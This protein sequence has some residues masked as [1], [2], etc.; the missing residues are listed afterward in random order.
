MTT[1]I[2]QPSPA[3]YDKTLRYLK[4]VTVE[5]HEART[6]LHQ[7]RQQATEPIAIVG[8]ACRYPGGVSSPAD[9]WRLVADGQD[10]ITEFPVDRGWDLE[11]IF[12]PDPDHAGTSYTKSGGFIDGA[13]DFDPAFFGIGP[14]EALAMD[15][16]QRLLLETSWEA[17]EDAGIDPTALR[18]SATGV[19]AG[20]MYSDYSWLT[21]S[22]P[23]ELGGHW[24]IGSAGSVA[25]GRV[26]YSFG[27]EGPAMTVDTACSSSLVALHLACQSL[28]RGECSL[29]LAGGATVLATPSVFVEFSRQRGL[30]P[31]GRCKSFAAAA[32]GTGWAEGVGVLL[33]ER[34]SDALRLGHPVLATVRGSAVNQDGASNGLTAPNGLAQERVVRQAL[35]AAGLEPS[36]VDVVEGHGTGTTLGDPIE[37]EALLATYGRDRPANRPLWL[38]S[39]KSNIGHTQA[40][41]GVAGIIKM[42][43]AMRGGRIPM[44]LH[45]DEPTPKV[46]WQ[47]GAVS[48]ATE[49]V[50]WQRGG[51]PRRAGVSSFGISGT[52]AHVILEEVEPVKPAAPGHGTAPV[53]WVLSATSPQAL[54]G[55]AGRLR[56][57]LTSHPG[58][59]MG[60]V[61]A[62]LTHSRARFNHRAVVVGSDRHELLTGLDELARGSLPSNAV[63]GIAGR[64]GKIV[65]LFSGQ[66]SQRAGMG[67]ELAEVYPVF[68]NALAEVC[69]Y[70]DGYLDRPLREVMF[71]A[72]GALTDTGPRL[73]DSP[74]DLLHQTR[75]AQA[76]LFALEVALFR[77]V[78]SWG[79]RPDYLLGHS[80]GEL[81]AAHVA[82]VLSLHDASALVAARGQLMQSMP[83]RGAMIAVQASAAEIARSIAGQPDRVAIA[84]VNGPS[85]VVLSGDE[86]AVAAQAEHWAV[87]GRR[88]RRLRVSH[89]FHSPLLDPILAEF[90]EVAGGLAYHRPTIPIVSNVTGAPVTADEVSNPQYWMR[91]ARS[92]VRFL[93]GI[94]WLESAGATI[95]LELGPN[96]ALTALAKDCLTERPGPVPALVPTLRARWPEATALVGSCA[97]LHMHG[98]DV[99]WAAVL[100]SP[101]LGHVPL[102]TYAFQRQ[103]FWVDEPAG[104]TGAGAVG[105]DTG[106]PDQPPSAPP[107]SLLELVRTQVASVL[108]HT[109]ADEI[110]AQ[111]TLLELGVDSMGAIEL[112]K[113]LASATGADLP[114]TLLVD[115]PTPAA[116]AEALRT[117]LGEPGGTA[118]SGTLTVGQAR[119]DTV[120]AAAGNAT[121]DSGT[122][123]AG[124]GTLTTL[125]RNA[126][127]VGALAEVVPVL[128]AASKFR[129][130]LRP[131]EELSTRAGQ[132]LVSNGQSDLTLV[133]VPS[134]LAGSGPHQ[135]ARFA[136]ELR[137]RRKVSALVLPGFGDSR[138]LPV[139]WSVAIDAM[140]TAARL[141]AAGAPF[142]L[143]GYSIGGVLAHAIA[144]KLQHDS[145]SPTGVVM[146]DTF[147]PDRAELATVFGWA[148]G[149]I[150]D[151]DHEYVVINDDNIL[152][153]GTYLRLF[154]EWEPDTISAPTLLLSADSPATDRSAHGWGAWQVADHIVSVPGNHFSIMEENAERSALAVDAWLSEKIGVAK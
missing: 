152:A 74:A 5:L 38:G 110:D 19:F 9:L 83:R 150:I 154:H 11:T 119:P 32:D 116:T 59:P 24:G 144:A 73:V 14:R 108:G 51:T 37:V 61:G 96:A 4:R 81:S 75:Y 18:G 12:H 113:R 20:L 76:A 84:A 26:A 105:L 50:P 63:Q 68:A 69:G 2:H 114:P 56:T 147:E 82:G 120:A 64:P 40:A 23:D 35:S 121:T 39:V 139:S 104:G 25:S 100:A 153:M 134:F 79:L 66:G 97:E 142:V 17:F 65:F 145:D 133:C 47:A 148:M 127:A 111:Q 103:R 93:D 72:E 122:G 16:Q 67:R 135:F 95:F 91:H 126:H 98:V 7:V 146:I 6:R 31:N 54:R 8:M 94:R 57:H 131:A 36:D 53:A 101:E 71:A 130:S 15:P 86:E 1:P 124:P 118:D 138:R 46:D 87:R 88:T 48:L 45:V 41:A 52:N 141:A 28:R 90:G 128:A 125:L 3:S 137:P 78:E 21:R 143:V 77:L 132:L 115:Q 92:T 123:Q 99:D 89:A 42:V 136:A 112:H 49:S 129:T 106:V 85:S 55:Q 107:S 30:S 27:F 60:V 22:S 80:I 109:S 102:P 70:L 44:T 43:M 33:V 140:A 13:A 34:L 10:A 62:A 151:R 149:Q 29:A 58:L 117:L